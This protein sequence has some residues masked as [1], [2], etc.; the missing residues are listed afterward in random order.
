[1]FERLRIFLAW[2]VVHCLV[3]MTFGDWWRLLRKH[4]FAVSP[5]AWHRI[6]FQMT[7]SLAN[8]INR[9]LEL[10]AYGSRLKEVAIPPPLFVLG[11][12]RSGT[13][14]L[15]YLL[16][17]DSRFAFPNVYQTFNPHTFLRTEWW[18]AP[19][20]RW[21]IPRFRPQDNVVLSADVPNED[22]IALCAMTQLSP[23]L[24]WVFPHTG[25]DYHRYLTFEDVSAD[26]IATWKAAMTLFFQKLTFKYGRP[27][28][29]KS[30]PHT[31]RIRLLLEMFPEARFV[32]I[33]RDPYAVFQSTRHLAD[34][35]RPVLGLQ[36]GRQT[37]DSIFAVYRSM[38]SAFFEQKGLIPAGRFCEVSYDEL[39]K[40]P[41]EVVRS[42]YESL[43]LKEF[44]AVQPKLEA[45]LTS[46][47]GYQ[48]NRHPELP[49]PLRRRI[50]EEWSRGFAEWGYPL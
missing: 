8:S 17:L 19:V 16:T 18:I 35:I 2:H 5:L 24:A 6:A 25:Q 48:K 38:Y 32:H 43:D 12:Y 44:D 41:V 15:H 14:H 21:L 1:M 37:D 49:E 34:R 10:R 3:G 36:S 27:L 47:S 23:Y 50:A 31:A 42:I 29:L 26:E 20:A 33:H 28:I 9:V 45:Y 4:R 46:I 7:V 22:E 30:P 11:H 40:N 39:T 13:T